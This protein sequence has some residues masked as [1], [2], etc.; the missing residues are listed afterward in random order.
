M[1]VCVNAQET[2]FGHDAR[3]NSTSACS[4]VDQQ[5]Q[6]SHRSKPPTTVSAVVQHD[7]DALM[8]SSNCDASG[9]V[10]YDGGTGIVSPWHVTSAA[11]MS[12]FA[13]GRKSTSSQASRSHAA[14]FP[15]TTEL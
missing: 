14:A 8:T 12:S 5:H 3:K 13:A 4:N 1:F 6:Q 7:D 9:D 2:V 15:L 10:S 11:N